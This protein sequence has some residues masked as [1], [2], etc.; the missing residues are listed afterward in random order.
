MADITQELFEAIKLI[1]KNEIEKQTSTNT[2]IGVVQERVE[3]SGAYKINYQNIEILASSLGG[4]YK[5]GDSVYV[6]L[7]NGTLSGVKFIVGKTNDRTPTITTNAGGLSESTLQMIQ[8]AIDNINNLTSDNSISPIEKQTL[9]SEWE[10]IKASYK[11][12]LESLKPYPEIDHS[13]LDDVYNRLSPVLEE[14]LA[15]MTVSSPVDG[16]NL[17]QLL[18]EYFNSES[19]I[20]LLIQAALRDEITYKADIVS[21]NGESFKNGVINTTLQAIIMRGKKIIND[22]FEENKIKWSKMNPDGTIVGGWTQYGEQIQIT[23]EDVNI[24]Q[25]FLLQVLVQEA[26]V[27]QDTVTIVDLNDVESIK[28]STQAKFSKTQVYDPETNTIDP[29]YTVSNQVIQAIIT[30]G[31][32]D[33]T[34][35]STIKWF[36]GEE[37]LV[38]DGRFEANNNSLIIKRNI[39]DKETPTLMIKCE[40]SFYSL[41]YNL[42]LTDTNLIDLSYIVNGEASYFYTA[43]ANS[44][45][46]VLDF[47]L[48]GDGQAEKKSMILNVDGQSS[49]VVDK[50]FNV[51]SMLKESYKAL[52]SVPE[53]N[54]YGIIPLEAVSSFEYM[55]TYSSKDSVQSTNPEDYTWVKIRGDNS[56]SG[57]LTNETIGVSANPD[58]EVKDYGQAIGTFIVMDGQQKVAEGIEFS[59]YSKTN[60]DL[61]LTT[62]GDYQVLSVEGSVGSAVLR[63]AYNGEVIDK[64]LTVIRVKDGF[65]SSNIVLIADSQVIAQLKDGTITPV[66]PFDVTAIIENTETVEWSYITNGGITTTEP[67]LGVSRNDLV[68]TIDPSK[69]DF[70]TLT[71]KVSD[72]TIGDAVTIAKVSDGADGATSI[73]VRLTPTAQIITVLKSGVVLPGEPII[74]RAETNSIEELQ[75]LYAVNGGDFVAEVPLG[76]TQSDSMTVAI[77]PGTSTFNILTIKA[78]DGEASDSVTIARIV[79]GQDG[80]SPY[81]VELVS[82]NGIVFQNGVIKTSIFA[83]VYRGT[84]DVTDILLPAQFK[85]SKTDKEGIVDEEW[86]LAHVNSGDTITITADDLF[87]KATFSCEILDK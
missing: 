53:D 49:G 66:E 57:Y 7:P 61:T 48:W 23:S 32:K 56:L 11:E 35:A 44:P 73:I 9:F 50:K 52:S 15:D 84:E 28:L 83:T 42:T 69:I 59:I 45:D 34:S 38:Y 76:V 19:A 67:P 63:A 27:A 31:G 1:A 82:A 78:T 71:I 26:V 62:L 43:W 75:Y 25:V 87:R 68:V 12:I 3:A 60:M 58:G 18:S 51:I 39:L 17:R 74:V 37:E 29:D 5:T 14:I 55:G 33:I 77:D 81:Q 40:V 79:D 2:I 46:G 30:K 72:G 4:V 86:A 20:R 22:Q 13:G 6:L 36:L 80:A 64:V 85:W 21:T 65:Q 41:E 8:D 16:K 24:K 47:S 54:V 10:Q 70:K